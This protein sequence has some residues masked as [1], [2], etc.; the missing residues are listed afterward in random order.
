VSVTSPRGFVASGVACGIKASGALDLSL[1]A[2][3]DGVPVSAAAVFTTNLATA[4]PVLVSRSH[5][6]A[7]GGRA[8]AVVLSS[9]NANAACGEQGKVDAGRMCTLVGQEIGAAAEAVLVCQTGLIGIPLPMACLESGIPG[10]VAARAGGPEAGELAA[11]AIMTTDTFA[12]EIVVSGDGF[13]IGAMAKGA[14]ML[15]PNMATMLAVITTDAECDPLGLHEAL[16]RAVSTSFNAMTVDGATSTNDTVVVLASGRAGVSPAP[17]EL[18]EALEIACGELSAMMV[19]DAEGATKVAHVIVTGA[20]S[21]EEAHRAARQVADS[22]LVKCSLNGEDPYWG[23]V[24]SELG[25]AAVA[26]DP[27]RTTIAY[28]GVEVCRHG[29]AATHDHGAVAAHMAERSIEIV[30][31]LGLGDG[32]GVVLTC[33]LGHGYI[34]ENRT[35]S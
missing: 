17:G 34:D 8:A 19:Q 29:I 27:E 7:T 16:A 25:S 31:D 1:V 20:R 13:A 22:N 9:G 4:A 12:K 32:R 10:L 24:L 3:D 15:A 28:G 33:D 14:A 23:R 11:R 6:A 35:T 30:C 26:F 5:L 21:D 2:T 18:A